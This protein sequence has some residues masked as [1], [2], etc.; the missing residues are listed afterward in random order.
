MKDI[1]VL[2]PQERDLA[3]VR[4]AGLEERY[5]VRSRA[6][7]STSSRTST[8]PPFLDAPRALPADGVLGTKDLSALLAPSSRSGAGCR[9]RRRM[10]LLACQHKPTARATLQRR[11]A[12]ESTPRFASS[13]A[14]PAVRPA[15]LRQAGGRA[16]SRRAP[17][18]STIPPTSRDA[19]ER[20]LHVP[21]RGDRR[22]RRRRSRRAFTA[23]SRGAPDRRRG[24]AR[25]LRS[26]RARDDD[27]RDRLRQVPGHAQLRALR[28]SVEALRGAA[29]GAL[30]H[31][32]PRPPG[33]RLRGRFLQR[34]VLR[35]DGGPARSSR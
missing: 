29:G 23:S 14:G 32:R 16:G 21:L 20:A 12:P 17:T 26:R 18:G 10:S 22:A 7:I 5:R 34:R 30:R 1:L 31:R 27:R 35:P 6:P 28:V 13:T 25:G 9:A 2:C 3:A 19:G 33:A 24:D 8:R 4:A 11:A 15:V